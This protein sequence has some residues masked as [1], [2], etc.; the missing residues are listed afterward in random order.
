MP[1]ALC[2]FPSR[3]LRKRGPLR[4]LPCPPP[5]A[6]VLPDMKQRSSLRKL[7]QSELLHTFLPILW[8]EARRVHI[9]HEAAPVLKILEDTRSTLGEPRAAKL[10]GNEAEYLQSLLFRMSFGSLMAM[11]LHNLQPSATVDA[12]RNEMEAMRQTFQFNA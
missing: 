9:A 11:L 2:L 10:V 4:L 12:A 8:F 3:K 5:E 1:Q 6:T 7:N